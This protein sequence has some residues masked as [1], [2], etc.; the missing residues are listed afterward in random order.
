MY[1]QIIKKYNIRKY[2]KKDKERDKVSNLIFISI[3]DALKLLPEN[4]RIYITIFTLW[5][6][7]GS[8]IYM[9]RWNIL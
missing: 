9:F 7:Y 5:Y 4:L 3:I 2:E 8:Y 1:L 6:I